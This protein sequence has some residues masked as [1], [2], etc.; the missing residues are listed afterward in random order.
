MSTQLVLWINGCGGTG[1]ASQRIAR[2]NPGSKVLGIECRSQNGSICKWVLLTMESA[3]LVR[4]TM[5]CCISFTSEVNP[6][7]QP[8]FIIF[9]RKLGAHLPV[10]RWSSLQRI[11]SWVLIFDSSPCP[12]ERSGMR[13]RR[14]TISKSIHDSKPQA[15][16]EPSVQDWEIW[17]RFWSNYYVCKIATYYASKMG[18]V[19]FT[20]RRLIVTGIFESVVG[21]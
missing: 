15:G 14:I 16:I 8:Y 3:M 13:Y 19:L 9:G 2:I 11:D 21:I 17:D 10:R 12:P 6:S 1:I 5:F 4:Q 18:M 7:F 20:T